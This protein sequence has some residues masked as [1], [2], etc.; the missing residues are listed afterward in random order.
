MP[1]RRTTVAVLAGLSLALAAPSLAHGADRVGTV[2]LDASR[3]GAVAV[4]GQDLASTG[5]LPRE[6]TATG[7]VSTGGE[8][9]GGTAA[10]HRANTQPL[11]GSASDMELD[12]DLGDID[13]GSTP[14]G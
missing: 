2:D 6:G 5:S 8:G 3:P 10:R 14:S 1:L 7:S 11:G 12:V 4:P 13:T 9:G